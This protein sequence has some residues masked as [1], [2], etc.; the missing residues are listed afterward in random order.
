MSKSYEVKQAVQRAK[1]TL[2]GYV[3]VRVK[4]QKI[5]GS[6]RSY[7]DAV[8]VGLELSANDDELYDI[9]QAEE[10]LL[11]GWPKRWIRFTWRDGERVRE[12]ALLPDPAAVR[13]NDRSIHGA[14]VVRVRDGKIVFGSHTYN[15]AAEHADRLLKEA[16]DDYALYYAEGRLI[17]DWSLPWKM[18]RYD[19]PN[20]DRCWE[21][22]VAAD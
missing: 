15:R 8:A 22:A 3:A 7:D 6:A 16:Y 10:G 5:L 4:D 12:A 11:S 21:V 20:D 13:V 9:L 2:T 1:K 14:I 17:D 18:G 19:F